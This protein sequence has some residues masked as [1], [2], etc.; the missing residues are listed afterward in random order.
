MKFNNILRKMGMSLNLMKRM[1][2]KIG[3]DY[4]LS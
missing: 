1:K 2:M 4:E 3:K